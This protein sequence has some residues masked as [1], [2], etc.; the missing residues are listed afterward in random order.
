MHESKLLEQITFTSEQ[1]GTLDTL[2]AA[3][4]KHVDREFGTGYPHFRGGYGGG[5]AYHNGHHTRSVQ[6]GALRFCQDTG[7]APSEVKTA[8]VAANEHDSVQLKP[9]GVM[10]RESAQRLA[11]GM[12]RRRL[13]PPAIAA[14]T[15]A[16]LGTEPIM[17]GSQLTGQMV[18]RLRFPSK[19]A[20]RVAL[21]VACGDFS[22]LYAPIGPYLAHR[23]WQ[24]IKVG[25]PHQ[26]PPMEDLAAFQK[27][28]LALA[29]NYRYPHPRGEGLFGGLRTKVV[30]Y[31]ARILKQLQQGTLERFDQ[32]LEQDLA[33]AKTVA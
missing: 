5:L 21:A 14:A 7:C 20:E 2:G 8:A 19:A 33:F 3:A 15:L 9:R 32:L 23:L 22:E 1:C 12:A 31:H 24:E 18:S 6:A 17:H 27:T 11:Q 25:S 10:E 29:D 16:I 26:S 30:A 4:L 28:Q 13:P